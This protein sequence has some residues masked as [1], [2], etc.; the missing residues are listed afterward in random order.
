MELDTL[1]LPFM[2]RCAILNIPLANRLVEKWCDQSANAIK[3]IPLNKNDAPPKESEIV[4][5]LPYYSQY[6][7]CRSQISQHRRKKHRIGE[8]NIVS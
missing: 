2:E 4:A 1:V 6:E 7:L 5:P 8:E 3:S